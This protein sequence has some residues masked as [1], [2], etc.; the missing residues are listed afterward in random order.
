MKGLVLFDIDNTLLK[1]SNGH[2]EAFSAGFKQVYGVDTDI[3]IITTSGLTDQQIIIEVLKKNGL[4]EDQILPKIKACMEVMVEHFEKIQNTTDVRV[5]SGV[6]ALLEGLEQQGFLIGL[7]TGNLEPIG[8]GKMQRVGLGHYFKPGGFG[9]ESISRTELVHI[10]VQKAEQQYGFHAADNVFLFGDTP[11]DILAGKE[12]GVITVGVASGIYSK[13]DLKN[14]AA[15]YVV[16]NLQD[17][18]AIMGLILER[19]NLS[20]P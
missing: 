5:L 15:D 16:D 10:A 9:N 2:A 18:K 20:N 11:K 1:N 3:H 7:V 4:T 17:T 8:R 19:M 14:A 6:L 12:A 13:E